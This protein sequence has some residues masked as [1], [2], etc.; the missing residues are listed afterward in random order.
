MN[1]FSLLK[2]YHLDSAECHRVAGVSLKMTF[3]LVHKKGQ[4]TTVRASFHHSHRDSVFTGGKKRKRQRE[5]VI[6]KVLSCWVKEGSWVRCKFR[7]LWIG[8]LASLS[9]RKGEGG[10]RRKGEVLQSSNLHIF[11]LLH[12]WQKFQRK[13]ICQKKKTIPKDAEKAKA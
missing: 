6:D 9:Q 7:S 3:L 12:G 8:F 5:R 4:E 10:W 13:F 11:C 1:S 2:G